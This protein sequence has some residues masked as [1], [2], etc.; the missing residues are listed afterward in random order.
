VAGSAVSV[1]VSSG[2][3][4][5]RVPNVVG[6]SQTA[7]EAALTSA[8]LEVGSVSP[9]VSSQSAG[10]VLAQS[11]RGGTSLPSGSK[12]NLTVAQAPSAVTV[13]DV[14]GQGEASAAAALGAAGLT[15][16]IASQTTRE[17]SQV[18]VV[19]RQ[20]PAGGRR[21]RKGAAV[22]LAVGTLGPQTTPTPTTPTPTT[23][24][25]P[26]PTTPATPPPAGG[27]PAK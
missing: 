19:L 26:T 18:G 11:P 8:G 9:R 16:K 12:V 27:A 23:P 3:A 25:T 10:S 15:P 22:T 4:Q 20:S 1:L 17:Q 2:P 6:E 14:V 5:V 21:V 24:T 7:A 13:P